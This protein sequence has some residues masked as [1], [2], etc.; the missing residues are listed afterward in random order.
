MKVKRM[1][2]KPRHQRGGIL[3]LISAMF[4]GSG[5]L[6]FGVE[7]APAIA[8]AGVQGMTEIEEPQQHQPQMRPEAQAPQD[9]Q[10]VLRALQEREKLLEER[11]RSF[12]TRMKAMTLANVALDKKLAA[13]EQAE[14]E[15]EETLALADGAAE[16]D[17]ARLTAM[18]EQMK[19]KEAAA[20]FEEMAPEFAAGFLARMKPESAAL[21]MAGLNPKTAYTLSVVLAGRNSSVPTQ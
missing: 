16:G 7:A 4:V 3:L 11:E 8:A 21:V 2:V 10:H 18:Y 20:L 19:P 5:V 15:L 1:L 6:R 12:E 13:L 17:L 14:A 9:L